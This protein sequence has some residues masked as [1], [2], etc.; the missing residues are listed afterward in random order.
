MVP[1]W[2][3]A[4]SFTPQAAISDTVVARLHVTAPAETTTPG[5]FAS[6]RRV[7]CLLAWRVS[8]VKGSPT[9]VSCRRGNRQAIHAS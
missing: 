4:A 3:S 6:L 7:S 9:G 1:I 2:K 5:A 8:R